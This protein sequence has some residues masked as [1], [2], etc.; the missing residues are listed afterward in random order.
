M[1]KILVIDDDN[2]MGEMCKEL[3]ESKGYASDV[4]T[5]GKEPLK[6][7]SKRNVH[8]CSY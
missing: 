3:L 5:S 4:V 2:A 1:K 6:R 7:C 8:D